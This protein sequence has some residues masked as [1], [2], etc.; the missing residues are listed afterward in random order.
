MRVRTTPFLRVRYS[1]SENSFAVS[2]SR[3]PARRGLP[4]D[5][6]ESEVRGDE[7]RRRLDRGTPRDGP[8]PRQELLEAERLGQVVVGPEVEPPD[9][10]LDGRPRAQDEDGRRPVA[11]ARSAFSTSSPESR[12]A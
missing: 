9:P 7:D 12:A 3:R 1:R 10:I 6:V 5:R 2:S 8:E 4:A 11:A